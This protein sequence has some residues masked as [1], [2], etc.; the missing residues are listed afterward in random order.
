MCNRLDTEEHRQRLRGERSLAN[1]LER[2]EP[3]GSV[4]R[5]GAR[6][7]VGHHADAPQAVRLIQGQYE[8]AAQQPAADSQATRA[9]VDAQPG[10]PE[11]RQ[12]VARQS[13]AEPRVGNGGALDG[14]RGDRGEPHDALRDDR[15]VGDGEMELELVLACVVLEESVEVGVSAGEPAAVVVARER[16]NLSRCEFGALSSTRAM[17]AADP[18]RS[19]TCVV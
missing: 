2:L 8:D 14:R 7:C 12:R 1:T 15:D 11:H 5:N 6:L 10:E 17:T 3:Q 13:L 19:P 9:Q 16:T 4:E 18:S